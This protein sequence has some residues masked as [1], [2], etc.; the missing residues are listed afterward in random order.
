MILKAS[1][2]TGQPTLSEGDLV[3]FGA[4]LAVKMAPGSRLWRSR[5]RNPSM[6]S[7][8]DE[9][10][11]VPPG[12]PTE[13]SGSPAPTSRAYSRAPTPAPAPIAALAAAVPS[14]NNELFK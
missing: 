5:R 6:N 3:T 7:T 1:H 10:A 9:L 8:E 4:N 14:T 13:S 12:A 2:P 11:G